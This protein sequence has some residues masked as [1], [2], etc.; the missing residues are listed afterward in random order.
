MF[1]NKRILDPGLR[2]RSSGRLKCR[3]LTYILL[4]NKLVDGFLDKK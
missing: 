3:K 2:N 4:F 1:Q